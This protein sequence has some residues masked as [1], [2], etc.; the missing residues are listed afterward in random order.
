M[1]IHQWA[2][3]VSGQC[4]S[5]NNDDWAGGVHASFLIGQRAMMISGQ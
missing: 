2:M 4:W 5:G 3:L 1:M